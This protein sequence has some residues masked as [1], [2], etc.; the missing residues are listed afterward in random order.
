MALFHS[1]ATSRIVERLS[2]ADM[3]RSRL[4]IVER[5]MSASIDSRAAPMIFTS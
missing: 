4:S 3:E 2:T 1:R 5:D